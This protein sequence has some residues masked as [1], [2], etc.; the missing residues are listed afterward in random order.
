LA[1]LL[2]L[3][4]TY[5]KL[6]KHLQG[7]TMASSKFSLDLHVDEISINIFVEAGTAGEAV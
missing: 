2:L 7:G 3:F 1:V 5:E 6:G 4:W